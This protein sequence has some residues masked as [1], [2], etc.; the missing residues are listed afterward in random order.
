LAEKAQPK[1]TL[2]PNTD[3]REAF[4]QQAKEL[5]EGKTVWRPTWQALGLNYDRSSLSKL[6]PR[7]GGKK[8]HDQ[9]SSSTSS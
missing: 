6:E 5:L 3:E 9:T 1:A 4:E 8:N 2:K 7:R